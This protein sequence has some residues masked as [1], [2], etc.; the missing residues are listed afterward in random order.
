MTSASLVSFGIDVGGHDKGSD[1]AEIQWSASGDNIHSVRFHRLPSRHRDGCALIDADAV[2]TLVAKGDVEQLATVTYPAAQYIAT[3][4]RNIVGDCP[5]QAI[6]IDCPSG[7]SR[8][9]LGHG[10]A[11]EKIQKQFGLV[12]PFSVSFQSTPSLHCQREHGG[13]WVWMILGMAL[14]ASLRDVRKEMDESE[15]HDF[16]ADGPD[17][18]GPL[19]AFPSATV[20]YLRQQRNADAIARIRHLIGSMEASEDQGRDVLVRAKN[21]LLMALINGPKPLDD[22][23]AA[24]IAA[25]STLPS[26]FPE[27][28]APVRMVPDAARRLKHQTS[29]RGRE[30]V[31]T[32]IGLA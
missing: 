2:R 30:G 28:Y 31:V 32:M 23:T 11:T 12:K 29:G 10:R 21:C 6:A 27:H 1:I 20:Q 13:S 18:Q 3:R 4:V 15:W 16:L 24:L 26:V 5:A 22:R 9:V 25:L 19:E 17:E 7:F 14:F 8:N